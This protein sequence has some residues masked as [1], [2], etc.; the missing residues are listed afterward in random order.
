[1]KDWTGTK[2]SAFKMLGASNHTNEQREEN[3]YYATD[4]NA[5]EEL[6]KNETFSDNVWE[7]AVGGGI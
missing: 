1:M 5:I 6:L 4:P 3:D 7:C 2:N